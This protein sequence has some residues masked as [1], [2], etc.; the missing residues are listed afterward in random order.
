MRSQDRDIK[1]LRKL[2]RQA[3]IGSSCGPLSSQAHSSKLSDRLKFRA[4]EWAIA[5]TNKVFLAL[6]VGSTG[7]PDT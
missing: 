4:A 6:N 2:L 5:I 3:E 1:A 7:G